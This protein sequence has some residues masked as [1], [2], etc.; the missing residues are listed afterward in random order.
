M[1]VTRFR[2]DTHALEM[3]LKK[4]GTLLDLSTI[5]SVELAIRKKDGV[6]VIV[7]DKDENDLTGK[8]YSNMNSSVVDDI[9]TFTFDVRVTWLDGTKTTFIKDSL[10]FK[11]DINKT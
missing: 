7:C 2:G 6:V 1:S 9:G 8:V 5:G 10:I 4:D 11:D 3:I